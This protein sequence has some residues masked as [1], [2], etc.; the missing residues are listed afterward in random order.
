MELFERSEEFGGNA[1]T[2]QWPD[3]LTSGLSVLAW[4]KSYFRNYCA[5]LKQ[6]NVESEAVDLPFYLCNP[7]G[8]TF[9]HPITTTSSHQHIMTEKYKIDIARW[10]RMIHIAK[11]INMFFSSS[12]EVSLYHMSLLNPLNLIS[13]RTLSHFFGITTSFWHDI[14]VPLYASSFLTIH[15]DTV[16]AVIAPTLDDLI[17]LC[18]VP[19]MHSWVTSSAEVFHKLGQHPKGSTFTKL[20]TRHAGHTVT[21]V[22]KEH[23]K[24]AL[25]T[26][27][28]MYSGYDVVVYATNSRH[29]LST[30]QNIPRLEEAILRGISYTDDTD[31]SFVQGIVH[32]DVS[33]LPE[34]CREELLRTYANFIQARAVAIPQNK[35]NH[36]IQ[37]ELYYENTF[38]LSSWLP[39]VR[40]RQDLFDEDEVPPKDAPQVSAALPRFVTYGCSPDTIIRSRCGTVENK[41]NHP[42]LNWSGLLSTQLLRVVQGG[43]GRQLGVYYCGSFTTPGNGHDLSFCSGW[44]YIDS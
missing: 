24:W 25:D 36:T 19:T 34:T 17:P 18:R 44:C 30:Y 41:S 29:V 16:P 6:L 20:W 2:F 31:K 35:G 23:D 43:V 10:T 1:K 5:L 8:E 39:A 7:Q 3:G 15:M 26:S 22:F 28:G 38:I 14:I 27:Q 40:R 9:A 32:S 37:T 33:I 12:A 11:T 4:P 21:R 42:S 13:L